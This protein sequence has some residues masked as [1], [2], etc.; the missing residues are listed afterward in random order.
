M[1]N[2]ASRD[3]DNELCFKNALQNLKIEEDLS[4]LE[5]TKIILE[6]FHLEESLL[7]ISI[8]DDE[9]IFD[10]EINYFE[11]ISVRGGWL[12]DGLFELGQNDVLDEI[13]SKIES[14]E[15]L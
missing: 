9:G 2:A 13:L 14:V 5:K 10:S 12:I 1:G 15:N 8:E 7:N 4:K 6:Q 11:D 3:L